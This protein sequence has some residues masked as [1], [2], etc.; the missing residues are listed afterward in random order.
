VTTGIQTKAVKAATARAETATVE[1]ETATV[2][3]E[4][5]TVEAA[6]AEKMTLEEVMKKKVATEEKKTTAMER[7]MKEALEKNT[8]EAM[9]DTEE[10]NITDMKMS[11]AMN[12]NMKTRQSEVLRKKR[13]QEKDPH[14][15]FLR[16]PLQDLHKA[17]LPTTIKSRTS[18]TRCST[19]RISFMISTSRICTTPHLEVT[20]LTRSTLRCFSMTLT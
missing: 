13:H 8:E 7:S 9:M 10:E 19:L 11:I 5:A 18:S 6:M 12:L 17:T 2:E 15:P 1:A 4:T 20:T 14:S 3:A 16:T